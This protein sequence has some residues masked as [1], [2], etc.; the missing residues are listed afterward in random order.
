MNKK[1]NFL[2]LAMFLSITSAIAQIP[3]QFK[4]QA[5]LRDANGN[6]MSNEDIDLSISILQGSASGTSV[7]TETH[8]TTTTAQGLINLNVGSIEDLSIVD[9]SSDIFFIEISMNGTVMGT[10]QL[11]SSPCALA[12]KTAK[13]AETAGIAETADYNSLSNL[14]TLFSG[15]YNDLTDKPGNAT[16][17]TDGFMSS[18]DKTKLDNLENANIT[19]GSGIEVSG[20]YPDI[21]ITNTS[22]SSGNAHYLGEEYLD[23]IIFYLYTGSDGQQHGLVVS[24]TETTVVWQNTGTQVNADRTE[25]GAYNTDLMTDSPAKDW[26]ASLGTEWYLPSM[27]ELSLLWHNRYHVNK[28]AR[29]IGST[30]LNTF[31]GHWSSTEFNADNAFYFNFFT[32]DSNL[33]AK[34]NFNTVRGIRAF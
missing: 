4:Y 5:V 27:D 33:A 8:S 2:V 29:A 9:F 31:M 11:L 21:T 22:T 18:T 14:P 24:K 15:S 19:A 34:A 3:S 17:S 12:A 13:T 30:L 16:T 25:D 26:I 28:T 10:S 23:G 32:G 1:I 6:I 20:T 7:F